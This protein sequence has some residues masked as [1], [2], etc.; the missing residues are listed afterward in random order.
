MSSAVSSTEFSGQADP[1]NPSIYDF[2]S[3]LVVTFRLHT[4]P[5]QANI[6]PFICVVRKQLWC[7]FRDSIKLGCVTLYINYV[8]QASTRICHH[9]LFLDVTTRVLLSFSPYLTSCPLQS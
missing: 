2:F 4:S 9:F 6:R 7:F 8:P 3:I 1:T 5:F